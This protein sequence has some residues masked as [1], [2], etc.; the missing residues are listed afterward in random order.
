[1]SCLLLLA[2]RTMAYM[3]TQSRISAGGPGLSFRLPSGHNSP[4]ALHGFGASIFFHCVLVIGMMRL[5]RGL[6][7]CPFY[8]LSP[9][10]PLDSL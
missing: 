7:P 9:R 5:L 2:V 10:Y 3:E 6:E 4:N 1:M 8:Y